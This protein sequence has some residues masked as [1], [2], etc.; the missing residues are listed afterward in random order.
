MVGSAVWV[1]VL[2]LLAKSWAV[3]KNRHVQ[4]PLIPYMETY[5]GIGYTIVSTMFIAQCVGYIIAGVTNNRVTDKIGMGRLITAG[6]MMQTI[7]YAIV[8]A[9]PPF[10]VLPVAWSIV[11]EPRPIASRL[12]PSDRYNQASVSHT[13]MRKPTPGWLACQTHISS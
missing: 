3:T 9:P 11:G 5:F 6:A 1:C 4:Q 13:K 8:I 7:A 10:A 2:G 12:K